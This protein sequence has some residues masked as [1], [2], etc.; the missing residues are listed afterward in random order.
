MEINIFSFKC[1]NDFYQVFVVIPP[2]FTTNNLLYSKYTHNWN[3]Q[4][5]PRKHKQTPVVLQF[6]CER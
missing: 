4:D 5:G 2:N 3:Y 6:D 1:K